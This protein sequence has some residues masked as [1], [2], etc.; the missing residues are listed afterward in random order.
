MNGKRQWH[1]RCA[2]SATV[3]WPFRFGIFYYSI[4]S[5]GIN[6]CRRAS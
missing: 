1:A 5:A 3:V 4:F 6:G 2:C